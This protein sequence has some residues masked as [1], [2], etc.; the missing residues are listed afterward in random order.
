MAHYAKIE[1]DIVTNV[2]VIDNQYELDGENYINTTLGLEGEWIQ[3]SYNDNIRGNFA[4]IGFTYDRANDVFI[5]PQP[6]PSWLLNNKWKWIPP[7]D[8]PSD[9]TSITYFWSEEDKNWIKY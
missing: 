7:I 4:G 5:S 3:T 1:N 8:Y 9:Y 2:I 6:Y